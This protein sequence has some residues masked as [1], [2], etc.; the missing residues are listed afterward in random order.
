V[1][2]CNQ[3][4]LLPVPQWVSNKPGICDPPPPGV[5]LKRNQNRKKYGSIPDITTKEN[6]NYIEK[7]FYPEYS[8][9]INENRLML[10]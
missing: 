5:F 10:P 3:P 4:Y 1:T 2:T 7:L 8:R 6:L 9:Q